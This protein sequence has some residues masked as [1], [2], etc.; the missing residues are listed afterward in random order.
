M[1][2]LTVALFAEDVAHEEFLSAV[3]HRLIGEERATASV[4]VAAAR[5]GHGRALEEFRLWQRAVAHGAV[6]LPDLLLVA[7]DA[8]CR[9]WN[10]VRA[11]IQQSVQPGR[12]PP[13]V[14][15]CPD[16]Y[17]EKWY[18]A[19]PESF[20]Q[21]V[22]AGPRSLRRKCQP[23][24]YKE[25]LRQA[26]RNAGHIPTLGGIEFA[27]EIVQAMDLYRAGQNEPSLRAFLNDC[28][29][30]IRQILAQ[31]QSGPSTSETA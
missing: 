17:I 2:S 1:P 23:G 11:E 5:G 25:L 15:A 28:R 6:G 3:V 14:V 21:A 26:I 20:A 31:V 24:R 30:Q 9:N 27:R 10:Q 4:N 12:L 16:P 22:G 7:R 8:N 13:L 19:D 29:D 18:M